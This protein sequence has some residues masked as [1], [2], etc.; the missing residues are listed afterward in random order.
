MPVKNDTHFRHLKAAEKDHKRSDNG[1]A[2]TLITTTGSKLWHFGYR[3]DG[4]QK[5]VA[6]GQYPI[7]SLADARARRDD[8]TATRV[9]STVGAVFRFAA[10]TGAPSRIRP[11]TFTAP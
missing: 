2:F 10:A 5:L 4:K 3:F 8:E 1:G 11:A 6:M 9:R 7:V